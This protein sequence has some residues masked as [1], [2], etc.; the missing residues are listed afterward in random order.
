MIK[1]L[2][3]E[4]S[5]EQWFQLRCGRITGTG[6]KNVM[7]APSTASYRGLISKVAAEILSGVIDPSYKDANM[8]HGIEMEPEARHCYEFT[9]EV[10]VEQVGFVMPEEDHEFH[11]WIGISPDGFPPGGG[12]EI[13]CPLIKTHLNYIK[14]N[15]MPNEYKWQVQGQLYVTELPWWDFMS[16]VGDRLSPFIIR[17]ERDEKMISELE[18]RLRGAVLDIQAILANY[19]QYSSE[20]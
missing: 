1:I 13:K 12:L 3:V 8:E 5:S 11:E 15:V 2:N 16:Y 19:E 7:S 10:E 18:D 9:Q 6:F 20:L 4:Q 14:S 17:V